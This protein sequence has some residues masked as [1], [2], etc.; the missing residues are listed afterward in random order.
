MGHPSKH[1]FCSK[2]GSFTPG[3]HACAVPAH[4][5]TALPDRGRI[6]PPARRRTAARSHPRS[7]RATARTPGCAPKRMHRRMS[8]Q[9]GLRSTGRAGLPRRAARRKRSAVQAER[10]GI[11]WRRT[12]SKGWRHSRLPCDISP[13]FKG[14]KA[15]EG[16]PDWRLHS[17]RNPKIGERKQTAE[18]L[19]PLLPAYRRNLQ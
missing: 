4:V 1:F 9:S 5:R 10:P 7:E 14:F 11:A 6:P 17:P 3:R 15:G 13:F 16:L 8:L 19:A 2:A 12:I 18:S